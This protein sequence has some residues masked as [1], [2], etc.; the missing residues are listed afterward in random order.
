MDVLRGAAI[1]V[2]VLTIN[3][4]RTTQARSNQMSLARYGPVKQIP[5]RATA[6]TH[7]KE[8][9]VH[10]SRRHGVRRL[11]AA[12]RLR[13]NTVMN[14]RQYIKIVEDA[15]RL[16]VSD[17]EDAIEEAVEHAIASVQSDGEL[18]ERLV[19]EFRAEYGYGDDEDEDAEADEY[20]DDDAGEPGD[21]AEFQKFIQQW[22]QSRV[23]DACS[24]IRQYIKGEV[25]RGYRVITAPADWDPAAQH[26][27]VYWSWDRHAA[28]AH[29]GAYGTGQIEWVMV[30]DLPLT[31]VDWP[32]TL[33]ANANPDTATST[34]SAS[35]TARPSSSCRQA[36]R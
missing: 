35:S 9:L 1:V 18:Y 22:A 33:A 2:P 20:G 7:K 17:P 32:T 3:P 11:I 21:S 29:W 25:I 30:A 34:R 5:I 13:I 27:G 19:D 31:I 8:F 24:T 12:G 4:A 10:K 6:V 15:A 36:S 14:I 28:Q 23:R 16:Q 26:P